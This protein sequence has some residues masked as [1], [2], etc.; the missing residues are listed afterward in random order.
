[1]SSELLL[2][3][4]A[5][6]ALEYTAREEE[7]SSMEKLMNHYIGV[8]DPETQELQLVPASKVIIRATPRSDPGN[9]TA[10]EDEN[11]SLKV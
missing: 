4:A 2:H 3:C 8:F 11:P 9:E 6:S 7:S 1:M 5:H 10:E